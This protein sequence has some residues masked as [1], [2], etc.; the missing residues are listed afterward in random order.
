MTAMLILCAGAAGVKAAIDLMHVVLQ[1]KPIYAPDNRAVRAIPAQTDRWIQVGDDVLEKEAVV[2]ELGTENYLTRVY[3]EK[4][5]ASGAKPRVI[6]LHAAYYTG[7]IDTVPHVPDRCFVGAGFAIT[8][9]PWIVD[10]PLSTAGW[11][12]VPASEL[13]PKLV[14]H[15]FT[16]RLS[17][18]FASSAGRG[19]RV[20][21]PTDLTP[22]RPLRIKITEFKGPSGL[23]RFEGYFFI[24]NG[25]CVPN[26]EDVRF[27]AFDLSTEYAYY[28]K[29]QVGSSDVGSPE[30]LAAG[31][32]SLLDDLLGELMTCVPDWVSVEEGRWPPDNPRAG[33]PTE[34]GGRR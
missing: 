12:A 8:G 30:E 34:A 11:L 28:L 9:G 4:S 14:G 31:A 16:T 33:K 19:R 27:K 23:H 29:V 20:H 5:P 25:E 2:E 21:L 17:Q 26:A 1:K 24:A 18:D 22:S 3:A 10:I 13:P 7:M 32:A 6:Q 15:V